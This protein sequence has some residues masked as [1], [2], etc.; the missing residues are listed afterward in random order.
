MKNKFKQLIFFVVAIIA[1]VSL[2]VAEASQE[3]VIIGVPLP[4][5]GNLKEFGIMMKNSFEMAKESINEAG[6]INGRPINIVFADDEGKIASIKPAFDKLIAA[7]PVMLVGG[8]ASGGPTTIAEVYDPATGLW[9]GAGT[10][11]EGREYGTATLLADGRV[12]FAGG[13]T[14]PLS[15]PRTRIST[16]RS[17]TAG[18]R[19]IHSTLRA[20]TTPPPDSPTGVCWSREAAPLRLSSSTR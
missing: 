14:S 8:Y 2:S 10:T 11:D 20:A 1:A 6:G 18:R 17:P 5:S 3:P 15:T 12:L 4:L 7:N 13:L 19:P 9:T 16:T